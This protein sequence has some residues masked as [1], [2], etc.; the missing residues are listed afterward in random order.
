MVFFNRKKKALSEINSEIALNDTTWGYPEISLHDSAQELLSALVPYKTA[1]VTDNSDE[2]ILPAGPLMI[3]DKDRVTAIRQ[4]SETL[5]VDLSNAD[6]GYALVQLR[7]EN[8]SA[9]HPCIERGVYHHPNPNPFPEHLGVAENFRKSLA[10]LRH[11][12]NKTG[13]FS[14]EN[15]TK[16]NAQE[17]IDLFTDYGTHFVSKTTVGDVIFQVFAFPSSRFQIIKNAYAKGLNIM[18]G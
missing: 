14:P 5:N 18:G 9:V 6:Y 4:L 2:L 16:N 3:A 8:G 1:K 10:L 17:Y 12:V 7:R 15:M 11:G 13:R